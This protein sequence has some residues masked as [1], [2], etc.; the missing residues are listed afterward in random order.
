MTAEATMAYEIGVE[1]INNYNNLN[2]LTHE[3]EDAGGFYDELVNNDGA[4]GLFN[5]GDQNA[6]EEDFKRLSKGGT[7]NLWADTADFVYFTG[8]GSPSGLYFRSDVPDDSQIECDH[9]T[10]PTNGDLRLGGDDLE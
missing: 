5:W 9:L 7:A 8:H 4:G 1:W 6:W 10:G 3:H 2:P